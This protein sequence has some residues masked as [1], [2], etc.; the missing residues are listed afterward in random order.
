MCSL[1]KEMVAVAIE[2]M[3]ERKRLADFERSNL[4]SRIASKWA[5]DKPTIMKQ[6]KGGA[7][8]P[9]FLVD[10]RAWCREFAPNVQDVLNAL[11]EEVLE[12]RRVDSAKTG[13]FVTIH[14]SHDTP[15]KYEIVFSIHE[16]VNAMV[17]LGALNELDEEEAEEE[18]A[19]EIQT[20]LP[21]RKRL[22]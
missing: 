20:E 17:N 6:I 16:R 19:G 10:T 13:Y 18:E 14:E 15:G 3:R 12:M 22:R 1:G 5:T 8:R 9:A 21:A 11:P 7:A 2:G 4:A